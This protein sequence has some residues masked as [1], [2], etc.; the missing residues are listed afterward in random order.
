MGY[1]FL[2]LSVLSGSAKGFCGKKISTKVA[3]LKG[4]FY[5]TLVRMLLCVIIGGVTVFLLDSA[6]PV[7]RPVTIGITALSGF[8]TAM[9]LVLWISGIK[10]GSYVMMDVFLMLGAGLTIVLCDIFLHMRPTASQCIG[11][12]IL[13]IATIIMCSYNRTLS[14]KLTFKSVLIPAFCCIFNGVADFSQ[15]L[16]VTIVPDSGIAVFNFYTY[17][18]ASVV[19]L[20]FFMAE[21]LKNKAPNDGK[22]PGVLKF[23]FIMAIFLFANSYFKTLAAKHISAAIL[24]PM[25]NGLALTFSALMSAL[26]FGEKINKMCFAGLC[27]AFIS[28][29]IMNL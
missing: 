23:I 9:M 20:L 12:F 17:L 10:T 28:L 5:I 14:G 18:F 1:L 8:S 29:I 4:I 27:T 24:Y 2:V 3:S 6:L 7:A 13:L 21:C 15:K 26:F 16:Y 25:T 11:Y 22:A 19:I